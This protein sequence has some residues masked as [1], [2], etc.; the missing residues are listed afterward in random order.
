[1]RLPDCG[2]HDRPVAERSDPGPSYEVLEGR[3]SRLKVVEGLL[4]K[5]LAVLLSSPF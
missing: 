3:F 5:W 4:K 1:M 2:S